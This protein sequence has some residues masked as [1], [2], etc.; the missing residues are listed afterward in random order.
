MGPIGIALAAVFTFLVTPIAIGAQPAAESARVGYLHM[1]RAADSQES[2]AA[3]RERVRELGW[4]EGRNLTVETRW[5]ERARRASSSPP[6]SCLAR[7]RTNR[8][9]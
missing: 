4:V 5:A 1:S 2:L 6:S 8:I 9:D 3:F 7:I